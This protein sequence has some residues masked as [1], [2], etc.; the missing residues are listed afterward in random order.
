[1]RSVPS[2]VWLAAII[3]PSLSDLPGLGS[4]L[5][6]LTSSTLPAPFLAYLIRIQAEEVGRWILVTG[7]ESRSQAS[8]VGRRSSEAHHGLT[9]A[10]APAGEG[11]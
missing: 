2:L 8:G 11:A 4:L 1:M 3:H 9:E 6:A 10:D 5:I 7:E